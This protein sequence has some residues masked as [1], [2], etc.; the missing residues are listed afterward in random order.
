ML[1]TERNVT[2]QWNLSHEV[3]ISS[4][5]NEKVSDIFTAVMSRHV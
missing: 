5:V 2:N 4:A 1:K 3:D